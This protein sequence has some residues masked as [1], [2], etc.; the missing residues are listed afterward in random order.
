MKT[1]SALTLAA[2]ITASFAAPAQANTLTDTLTET[3]SNQLTELSTN[4]K[5]Q[6]QSALEQTVAELFF[7][8]GSQ[9]AEQN[10]AK[11]RE[12]ATTDQQ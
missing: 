11:T 10:V 1:L 4:I 2:V 6:A 9:Q 5:H 12:Q 7:S 3:V 8:A